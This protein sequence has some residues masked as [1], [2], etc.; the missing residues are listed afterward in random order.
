ML[1]LKIIPKR[2]NR[3]YNKKKCTLNNN[4]NKNTKTKNERKKKKWKI[5]RE[6]FFTRWH[7]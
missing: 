1:F 5:N 4:N 2:E 7:C 6:M 3:K